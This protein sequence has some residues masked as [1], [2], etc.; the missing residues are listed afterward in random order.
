[1]VELNGIVALAQFKGA[2]AGLNALA[3]L[4]VQGVLDHYQPYHAVRA[5]LYR[6][7]GQR[8]TA[9]AAYARALDLT[10][11]A[12]EQRFLRQRLAALDE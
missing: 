2:A 4:E 10:D 12:A 9:R 6:R 7:A 3:A 5:D 1:M 8:G 11:N